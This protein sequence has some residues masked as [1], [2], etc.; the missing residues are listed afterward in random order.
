MGLHSDFKV[1]LHGQVIFSDDDI[2]IYYLSH[3]V[4]AVQLFTG[5]SEGCGPE[6]CSPLAVVFNFSVRQN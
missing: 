5:S 2:E 6:T 3:Y 4:D 1:D